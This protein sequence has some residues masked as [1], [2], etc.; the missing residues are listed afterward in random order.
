M[1]AALYEHIYTL[2][3]A[4]A[5]DLGITDIWPQGD[6]PEDAELPYATYLSIPPVKRRLSTDSVVIR[7]GVQIDIYAR[8]LGAEEIADAMET[9][10][11]GSS[12]AATPGGSVVGNGFELRDGAWRTTSAPEPMTDGSKF[13]RVSLLFQQDE[14][15]Y[16]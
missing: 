6:V 7:R 16:A 11:V 3:S 13:Y 4:S 2:V 10:V 5:E 12:V 8:D 15:A 14:T 1:S 9:L